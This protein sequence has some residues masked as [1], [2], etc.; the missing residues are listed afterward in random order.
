MIYQ[1][2]AKVF[3]IC[4]RERAIQG[5]ESSLLVEGFIGRPTREAAGCNP[6]G[7]GARPPDRFRHIRSAQRLDAMTPEDIEA[8]MLALSDE[9]INLVENDLP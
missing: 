6:H 2:L 7:T 5:R 1:R 9:G 3:L 4:S 8:V